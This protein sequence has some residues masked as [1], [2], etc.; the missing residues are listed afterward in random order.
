MEN[1]NEPRKRVS[2][3]ALRDAEESNKRINRS[4]N[5]DDMGP[6]AL[7]HQIKKNRKERIINEGWVENEIRQR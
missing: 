5:Q 6:E 1:R 3:Q 2:T 7:L 4:E